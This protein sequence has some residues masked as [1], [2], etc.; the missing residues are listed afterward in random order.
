MVDFIIPLRGRFGQ[1]KSIDNV[2]DLRDTVI[3]GHQILQTEVLQNL[4]T[5]RILE[6]NAP[7]V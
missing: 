1:A 3:S 2:V 4:G 7:V 6:I 5:D